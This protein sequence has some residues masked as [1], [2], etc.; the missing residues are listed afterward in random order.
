MA[1]SNSRK[2]SCPVGKV[3]NPQTGRCVLKKGRLGKAVSKKTTPRKKA[4]YR[5]STSKK[6]A[7]R[8]KAA[9]RKSSPKPEPKNACLKEQVTIEGYIEPR[10]KDGDY[11]DLFAKPKSFGGDGRDLNKEFTLNAMVR[12]W[13]K[14]MILKKIKQLGNGYRLHD[15]VT[16]DSDIVVTVSGPDETSLDRFVKYIVNPDKNEGYPLK[17]KNKEWLVKGKLRSRRCMRV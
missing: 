7:P 10:T 11:S 6:T 5:K 1:T 17:W 9:S 15:I 13:Y 3:I 2:K 12:N 8:K 16:K 4:A 14:S